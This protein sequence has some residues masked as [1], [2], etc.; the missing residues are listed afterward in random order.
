[1]LLYESILTAH[2]SEVVSV[3]K[4]LEGLKKHAFKK[5]QSGNPGGKPKLPKELKEI[6]QFT[7]AEM[8]RVISKYF[9]MDKEEINIAGDST[10]LPMIEVVIARTIQSSA[11]YGDY[12]KVLP[13][14]DRLCGKV[15]EMI[16][17]DSNAPMPQVIITLPD[18]GKAS[19][20][21]LN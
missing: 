20:D 17:V 2:S 5:G 19:P 18:N 21:I 9:R 14:V 4:N 6:V 11:K 15:K 16:E 12:H 13:L 3:A 1:M 7:N 8:Q 10:T